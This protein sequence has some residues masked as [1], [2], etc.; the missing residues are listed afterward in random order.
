MGRITRASVSMRAEGEEWAISRRVQR[1]QRQSRDGGYA[2][3]HP[4]ASPSPSLGATSRLS[5]LALCCGRWTLYALDGYFGLLTAVGGSLAPARCIRFNGCSGYQASPITLPAR[6]MV[7]REPASCTRRRRGP[8]AVAANHRRRCPPS[9]P[10]LSVTSPRQSERAPAGPRRPTTA[11]HSHPLPPR[12]PHAACLAV[13]RRRHAC[14]DPRLLPKVTC[15]PLALPGIPH[16]QSPPHDNH[17]V[18]NLCSVCNCPPALPR[19]WSST[20]TGA[21]WR[22]RQYTPPNPPSPPH[23]PINLIT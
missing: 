11:A 1:G 10:S 17:S 21:G 5:R 8:Q 6:H 2:R 3:L 23:H 18:P 19:E 13:M 7:R 9:P 15:P 4:H 20:C 16:Q 14:L 22:G 12:C